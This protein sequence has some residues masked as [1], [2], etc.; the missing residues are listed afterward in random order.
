VPPYRSA[1]PESPHHHLHQPAAPY[2]RQGKRTHSADQFKTVQQGAST[3]V[4]LATSPLLTGIGDRYFVDNSE[5]DVLDRRSG[6]LHGVARYAL[7]PANGHRLW[8]V[9]EQ[10]LY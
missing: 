4:L 9:T 6:T 3:S 2:R 8:E 1:G 7:D 10:L 5:T